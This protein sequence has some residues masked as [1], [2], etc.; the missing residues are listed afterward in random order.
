MVFK[1]KPR[2]ENPW[3]PYSWEPEDAYAVQALA[4]GAANADQQRHALDLVVH[5]LAGTYDMSFRPGQN[6]AT[7]FAEGKRAVGLELVKLTS[8]NVTMVTG[9]SKEPTEQGQDPDGDDG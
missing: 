2:A 7:E 8:L 3:Q 4:K 6:G 9:R 5:G 1:P